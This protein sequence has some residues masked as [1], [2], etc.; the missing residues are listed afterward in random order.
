MG[1]ARHRYPG[2]QGVLVS[3]PLEVLAARLAARGREDAAGIAERLA[4]D[5]ALPE[6]AAIHHLDNSGE[7]AV[8][9]EALV[10]LLA[11]M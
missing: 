2:L 5:V 7:L 9:G 3:A 6:N 8:A 11:G 4:H 10:R 1:A